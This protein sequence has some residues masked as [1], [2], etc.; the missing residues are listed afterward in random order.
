MDKFDFC[1]L[2]FFYFLGLPLLSLKY[3]A[4][5]HVDNEIL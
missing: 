5:L 2:G 3:N 4:F 1:I